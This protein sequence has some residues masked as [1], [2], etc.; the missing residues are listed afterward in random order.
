MKTFMLTTF[1]NPYN[2]FEEFIDW[3]MFDCEKGHNCSGY[4]DR[5]AKIN[6]DM[7]ENEKNI[8]IERAIDEIIKYD[9]QNIYRKVSVDSY[10]SSN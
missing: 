9:F 6:N 1:D 8:E 7:T 2:P 3:Y 10:K 5:I 4:L